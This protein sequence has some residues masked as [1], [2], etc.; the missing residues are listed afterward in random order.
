MVDVQVSAQLQQWSFEKPSL[1]RPERSDSSASSPDLYH[2]DPETLR[3]DTAAVEAPQHR[4]STATLETRSFQERYMSSEEDLSPLEH[5][6]DSEDDDD[7]SIH[8]FEKECLSARRMSVSRWAKGKSCDLAITVSYVS[9]GRPKM[10]ELATERVGSPILER[11]PAQRTSSLAQLPIA[12]LN[13]LRKTDQPSRFSLRFSS[14]R[15]RSISPAASVEPQRPATGRMPV[16]QNS[17]ESLSFLSTSS[18]RSG[19]P[20]AS[21]PYARPSSAAAFTNAQP[22]SSLYVVANANRVSRTAPFPPLT[23]QSPEPHAFLNSDPYENT[24]TNAASP[25]IKSTSHRRLRSISQKL[26]LAKIAITP[27]TKKWDS[28]INGRPNMPPT[29]STPHTPLT[30]QTAPLTMSTSSPVNRLRRNSRISRP[31]SVREPFSEVPPVPS[32]KSSPHKHAQK[33]VARGA[34]EREPM[35]EL[36][37][38]LDEKSTAAPTIK[39]RRVR[40]R[41]SLMDLL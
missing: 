39:A 18:P 3:L 14:S 11:E 16:S 29:P 40:K 24:T 23:P 21:E 17:S 35:L 4:D 22:R 15:P 34:C 12:A 37:P 32:L 19:S 36:P 2:N 30:P 7:V 9:V 10:I 13:K 20:A 8:D 41:K 38:F 1:A 25:L 5:G 31:S 28:R 27:S 26:S 33:M 6:S